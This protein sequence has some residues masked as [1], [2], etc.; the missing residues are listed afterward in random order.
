M[1]NNELTIKQLTV[2][3]KVLKIGRKQ[4]TISVFN[5]IP[6]VD[7]YEEEKEFLYS[8]GYISHYSPTIHDDWDDWELWGR[9]IYKNEEYLV[10]SYDGVLFKSKLPDQKIWNKMSTHRDFVIWGEKILPFFELTQLF[11]AV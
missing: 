9:V 11:I 10:G 7:L 1:R 3:V 2:E 4:C 5:Q 8:G 6:S